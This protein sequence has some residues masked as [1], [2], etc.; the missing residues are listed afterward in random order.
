M[1]ALDEGGGGGAAAGV[2]D[3][4]VVEQLGDEFL[5]LGVVAVERFLGVGGGRQIGVARIAGGLRVREDHLDV[6]ADEVGP[7]LDVLGIAGA[8]E[9]GRQRIEGR[10]LVGEI[11]LPVVGDE[12]VLDQEVDVGDLVEGDDVGLQPLDDGARLL[13]GA[14]MRLVDGDARMGGDE[15]LVLGGEQLACDVVGGV[16]QLVGCLGLQR[17]GED[18]GERCA[19]EKEAF[20]WGILLR[21][22]ANS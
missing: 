22:A 14:G 10:G 21:Q 3:R 17:A 16:E 8:D 6:V 9:E 1:F 7:V 12:A 2:E 15:R 19:D 18:R 4:H 13:G 5:H 11:L 20:H